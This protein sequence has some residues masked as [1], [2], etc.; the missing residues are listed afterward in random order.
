MA[1]WDLLI[2]I[3]FFLSLI[4]VALG[5]VRRH[6]LTS[7]YYL[8]GRKL[9][10]WALGISLAAN[11]ASAI[12]LIGAPAFVAIR[13]GGGLTWLQYELAVPLAMAVLVAWGVPLLYQARVAS[14]YAILQNSL[15]V[16][17]RRSGSWL[18]LVGRGGST[19]VILYASALVVEAVTGLGLEASLIVVGFAALAYTTLGGL[20]ADVV[21]DVFQF[22]LLW[23]GTLLASLILALRLSGQGARFL[24]IDPNRL[25]PLD[26]AG[27]GFGDNAV[28]SFW[29]MLLGGLFL[30]LSYYGCDQTQ[31][32]RLLSC[33]SLSDARRALMIASFL[34]F[35][36]VLTYCGFGLLLAALVKVDTVFA[37]RLIGKPPDSLVPEFIAYWLPAGWRGI[38]IVGI[39]AAA[40]SSIDSAFNS[41]S[42]V[43]LEEV[44]P[45]RWSKSLL[46]A[47]L[48]TIG[49]GVATVM[50]AFAFSRAAATTIEIVN[51]L[52]S[53]V[54]GPTLAL[55]FAA[56][57]LKPRRGFIISGVMAGLI[58][59][60]IIAWLVPGVSWM[61]WNLIGFLSTVFFF[62]AGTRDLL[63]KPKIEGIKTP[64]IIWL[65][66]LFI[67]ILVILALIPALFG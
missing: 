1:G 59:T 45:R 30:Y 15:G 53:A 36:L 27:H 32:Q 33:R 4:I 66:A 5:F 52:G 13:E 56:L 58:S 8:A 19:G 38:A 2:L 39:L 61:W 14:V 65:M 62:L 10:S 21:T 41:L 20:A 63:P 51:R 9:P 22:G 46:A 16:E 55:F 12:S 11:Q 49:W 18:F 3:L 7:D 37:S 67:S 48:V 17:G 24:N 35:P 47:R 26:F 43:T 44:L 29:P 57:W 23:G 25:R 6:R 64:E 40:L 54:Y 34:R 50:A 31:V 28:F 60:L 42:A